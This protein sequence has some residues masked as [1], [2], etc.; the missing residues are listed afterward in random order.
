MT[1]RNM[2]Y[3]II[4][5]LVVVGAVLGYQVYQDHKEPKG[6]NVNIGP[7]GLSIKEK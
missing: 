5:A 4:G 3:L 6:L 1:S 2:L 7:G